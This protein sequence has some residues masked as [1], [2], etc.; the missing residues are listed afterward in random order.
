M[1]HRTSLAELVQ[2][3]MKSARQRITEETQHITDNLDL[4]SRKAQMLGD[5]QLFFQGAN[6]ALVAI[7]LSEDDLRPIALAE[8]AIQSDIDAEQNRFLLEQ[9]LRGQD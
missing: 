7:G 6:E 3:K 9:E 5:Y 8:K 2:T 1:S 4:A